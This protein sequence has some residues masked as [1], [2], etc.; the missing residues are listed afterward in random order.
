LNKNVVKLCDFGISRYMF[1]GEVI[2]RQCGTPAYVAPE[3]INNKGY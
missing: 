1:P 2:K 3:V